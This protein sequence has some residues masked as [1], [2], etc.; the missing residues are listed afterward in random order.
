M[1]ISA[2]VLD[3]MV[4]SGCSAEQIAAV[5]KAAMASQE[6]A[7]EAK[8]AKD[9]ERQRRSRANR[10]GESRG[11]T[12]TDRDSSGRDVTPPPPLPPLPSPGPLPTPL[13]PPTPDFRSVGADFDRFWR[14]Y[15]RRDGSN[16]RKP[17]SE[18]FARCIRDGVDPATL[19]A[20]AEAY[21]RECDRTGSNGTPHVA[22]A[23]TWFNQRRWEDYAIPDP[24]EADSRDFPAA[25][26]MLADPEAD[27]TE[28]LRIRETDGMEAA[29]LFAQQ[30][31]RRT[32]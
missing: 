21:R 22:Q 1:A 7:Q 10:H 26:R 4:A 3:A 8:R 24:P 16:P 31:H 23:L 32:A 11:V 14:A 25:A 17:A 28:L 18:K 6:R 20:A 12:V 15:P 27:V 13:N 2:D 30:H 9:A 29:D 19:I 5:V